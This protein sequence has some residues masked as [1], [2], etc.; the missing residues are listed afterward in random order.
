MPFDPFILLLVLVGP[1]IGSF[2]GVL[3]DRLPRNEGVIL[4][5]SECR[6]CQ[7]RLGPR[8]LIPVLSYVLNRGKCRHCGATIP[9]WLL[10]T[11]IA[12]TGLAFLAAL[13]GDTP[14][15]AWSYAAFLWLLLTLAMTDLTTFRLPDV[16]TGALFIVALWLAL[17][18]GGVGPESAL[19]GALA[20]TGSFW[21]L[22]HLYRRLRKQEGM[23]LGD[24]KL[25]AGLGAYAGYEDLP[26]IVLGA[27]LMG[28]G[29]AMLTRR[30]QPNRPTQ[31]PIGQRALP[32]GAA[33]CAATAALWLWRVSRLIG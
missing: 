11:E 9:P 23:G 15:Q 12:A 27:A 29:A 31:L 22:R 30:P 25:M 20:G 24:V 19:I 10:Y 33:L 7:F 3:A 4:N 32:F 1:F 5:H 6:S 28:L 26:L 8:D 14:L 18:P 21:L 2:L 17:L 13:A 16:L